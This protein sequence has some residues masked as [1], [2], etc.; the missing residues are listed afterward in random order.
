[1]DFILYLQCV[2]CLCNV[3]KSGL[4]LPPTSVAVAKGI[5]TQYLQGFERATVFEKLLSQS[6][7]ENRKKRGQQNGRNTIEKMAYNNQ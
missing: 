2:N 6:Q 5:K 1:M 7:K 4:V 3:G